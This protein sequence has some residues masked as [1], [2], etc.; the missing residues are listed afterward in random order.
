MSNEKTHI[1]KPTQKMKTKFAKMKTTLQKHE[2]ERS[3][4]KGNEK[5]YMNNE[6]KNKRA[7]KRK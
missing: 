3:N 5:I 1:P 2:N 6:M 4:K 7:Q